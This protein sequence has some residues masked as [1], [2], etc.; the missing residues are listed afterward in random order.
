VL[1][2][3]SWSKAGKRSR[4]ARAL[5]YLPVRLAQGAPT[6]WDFRRCKEAPGSAAPLGRLRE[7]YPRPLVDGAHQIDTLH[8]WTAR[9]G[10][11]PKI[12]PEVYTRWK[13]VRREQGIKRAKHRCGNI[14]SPLGR[15]PKLERPRMSHAPKLRLLLADDHTVLR[16]G[17]SL[18]LSAVPDMTV[19]GEAATGEEAFELFLKYD[20]D[21]LIL[22]LQ[23]PG[24]G[25]VN[26]VEQILKR[27]PGAKI[28]ILTAYETEEDIYRAM[29]AGAIGYLLKDTP[30][31]ELIHAIR[32]IASGQ[33]YLGRTVGAKL[34]GRIGAPVLTEREL[35]VLNRIAAGQANKEIA[36]AL[37]ISEGTVKSHVNKIM[38]K[39]GAL[40]RT[41]AAMVGLRKG[42]IRI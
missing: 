25:G 32:A 36:D 15:L 7:R 38:Q 27:R 22:D 2:G 21:V 6:P 39:L 16:E 10:C 9:T 28:L 19:V 8:P 18:I 3:V 30:P 13:G 12:D 4:R 37:S 1:P 42:L 41:D 14:D 23:M 11:A 33:R 34:A 40:S 17:L 5:I 35:S 20:P 24:K 26:T 31:D 29:H